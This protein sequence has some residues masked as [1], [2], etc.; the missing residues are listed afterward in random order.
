MPSSSLE[1]RGIRNVF[2]AYFHAKKRPPE[3][4]LA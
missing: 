4:G 1:E 2:G 3:G